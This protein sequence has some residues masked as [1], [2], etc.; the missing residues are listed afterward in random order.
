MLRG[1]TG[2]WLIRFYSSS[3]R[4]AE[5]FSSGERHRCAHWSALTGWHL[6]VPDHATWV[7]D[8]S[9]K[10]AI[11][12]DRHDRGPSHKGWLLLSSTVRGVGSSHRVVAVF[13]ADA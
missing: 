11:T 13:T 10:W 5:L 8:G 4:V 6:G 12:L 2:A 7:V 9:E 3:A 1:M